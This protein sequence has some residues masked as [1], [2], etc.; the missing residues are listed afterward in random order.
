MQILAWAYA[1]MIGS[2]QLYWT[3]VAGPRH[4][5]SHGGDHDLVADRD[6]KGQ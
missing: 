3:F 4:G 6:V 2:S 5:W 1:R